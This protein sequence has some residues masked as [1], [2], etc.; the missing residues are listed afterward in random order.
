MEIPIYR[1]KRIN[2]D[3]Y[4]E[5]YYLPVFRGFEDRRERGQKEESIMYLETGGYY[6]IDS[7]TL[8][9]NFPD[10]KDSEGTPIFASLSEDGKGGDII[11]QT[12]DGFTDPL[13]QTKIIIWDSESSS[14]IAL[15]EDK[16]NSTSLEEREEMKIIGIQK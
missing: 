14:V 12:Y 10:M 13:I 11:E 16:F 8:S 3:E 15:H 1:A 6:A 4:V 7:S 5:G 2:S 9:I